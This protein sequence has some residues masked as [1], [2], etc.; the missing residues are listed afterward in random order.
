MATL[1]LI[2][3]QFN[4]QEELL[5]YPQCWPWLWIGTGIHVNG[6]FGVSIKLCHIC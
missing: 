5:D 4:A 6:E 3:L 2:Q 1:N